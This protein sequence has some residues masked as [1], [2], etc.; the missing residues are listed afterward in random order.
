ME[1]EGCRTERVLRIIHERGAYGLVD[2]SGRARASPVVEGELQ[3]GCQLART[4][5]VSSTGGSRA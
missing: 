5:N 1:L 3:M 2:D 4:A